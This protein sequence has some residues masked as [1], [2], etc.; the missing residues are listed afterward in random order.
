MQDVSTAF[1]NTLCTLYVLGASAQM[2]QLLCDVN[3]API[4]SADCVPTTACQNQ[5]LQ[6]GVMFELCMSV[7]MNVITAY[8]SRPESADS[9]IKVDTLSLPVVASTHTMSVLHRSKG[10]H[11]A[12]GFP[13]HSFLYSP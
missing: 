9:G 5:Y 3:G 12:E 13:V 1:Y 4:Y 7:Y 8:Y 2:L 6:W 10:K 11:K